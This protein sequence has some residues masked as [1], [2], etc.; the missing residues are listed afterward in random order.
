M[1]VQYALVCEPDSRWNSVLAANFL[2]IFVSV[3]A[4]VENRPKEENQSQ[5]HHH[6]EIIGNEVIYHLSP[7]KSIAAA[8]EKKWALYPCL[9]ERQRT[10]CQHYEFKKK[11][12]VD[13]GYISKGHLRVDLSFHLLLPKYRFIIVRVH[14]SFY[15]LPVSTS[16]GHPVV[17]SQHM[18]E[19]C[20]ASCNQN[21]PS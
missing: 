5:K 14:V 8:S 20:K 19:E 15:G 9:I 18:R 10:H 12:G 13:I 2:G 16:P 1:L 21:G 3:H 11:L 4:V 17:M 6:Q 7:T